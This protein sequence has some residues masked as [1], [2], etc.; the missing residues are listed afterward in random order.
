MSTIMMADAVV[1]NDTIRTQIIAL[2]DRPYSNSIVSRDISA[3]Q[4]VS[5]TIAINQLDD[6]KTK[7]IFNLNDLEK[8]QDEVNRH[9]TECND[10]YLQITQYK[11]NYGAGNARILTCPDGSINLFNTM[12]LD[13]TTKVLKF[14]TKRARS[15]AAFYSAQKQ[16]FQLIE[17]F[18]EV[19]MEIQE[20]LH[21]LVEHG[22]TCESFRTEMMESEGRIAVIEESRVTRKEG[23]LEWLDELL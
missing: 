7:N 4:K 5:Y 8:L 9:L 1:D 17:K 23:W 19:E 3:R 12:K 18:K 6:L 22:I 13:L 21:G 20:L 2:Q 15:L 16:F 14:D 10:H 11:L